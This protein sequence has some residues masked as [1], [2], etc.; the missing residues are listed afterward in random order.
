MHRP[1]WFA[2]ILVGVRLE[3]TEDNDDPTALEDNDD[4]HPTAL[5]EPSHRSNQRMHTVNEV[6]NTER[7]YNLDLGH[8]IAHK[9]ALAGRADNV[10]FHPSL[11]SL[12][13]LHAELLRK[14]E[15]ATSDADERSVETA[16][17]VGRALAKVVPYL[18][19]YAGY[20]VNYPQALEVLAGLRGQPA[21]AS[22]LSGVAAARPQ[23]DSLES[24]L[25]KPVQRLCKYPLFLRELLK[26]VPADQP[27]HA[28][29]ALQIPRCTR[30]QC[31]PR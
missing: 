3:S 11:E 9:S 1:G 15:A 12:V 27:E 6:L 21:A 10:L 2:T 28:R 16:T 19:L 22:T 30:R 14:L 7:A 26:L 25:I 29:R 24:L 8:L 5:E 20:C 4:A 17:A 13:P 31:H 18:K 23:A